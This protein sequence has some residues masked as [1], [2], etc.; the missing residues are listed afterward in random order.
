MVNA[1]SDEDWRKYRISSQDLEK[2]SDEQI[3]QLHDLMQETKEFYG[4]ED[5]DDD[6]DIEDVDGGKDGHGKN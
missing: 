2:M 1:N 4:A 6:A 3:I 5:V